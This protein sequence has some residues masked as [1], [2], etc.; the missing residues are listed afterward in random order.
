MKKP[1]AVLSAAL[2][3]ALTGCSDNP[4]AEITPSA[5]V[6]TPA[7]SPSPETASVR[8]YLAALTPSMRTVD[9]WLDEWKDSGCSASGINDDVFCGINITTAGWSGGGIESTINSAAQTASSA[10]IG[11]PPPE[12]E[13]I[14]GKTKATAQN[15]SSEAKKWDAADCPGNDGCVGYAFNVWRGMGDLSDH[16]ASMEVYK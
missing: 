1:L 10:Y 15:I 3:L 16:F 6:S 9:E 2:I 4:G 8:D 12:L 13:G 11:A 5:A 7:V 14:L